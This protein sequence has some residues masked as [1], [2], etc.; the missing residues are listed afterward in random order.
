M[1]SRAPDC[2]LL[3]IGDSAGIWW[4]FFRSFS[5]FLCRILQRQPRIVWQTQK[6]EHKSERVGKK[7][8]AKFIENSQLFTWSNSNSSFFRIFFKKEK[9][10]KGLWFERFARENCKVNYRGDQTRSSR[11][12]PNSLVD[13]IGEIKNLVTKQFCSCWIAGNGGS[14]GRKRSGVKSCIIIDHLCTYGRTEGSGTPDK[15]IWWGQQIG[16]WLLLT[17]QC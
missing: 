13:S 4:P 9:K 2:R 14:A 1:K 12:W 11:R 3:T 10:R 6:E 5:L 17:K 7:S 8:F 16:R 15:P